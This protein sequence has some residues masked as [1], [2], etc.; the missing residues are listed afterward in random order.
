MLFFQLRCCVCICVQSH[1]Y[2]QCMLYSSCCHGRPETM[3]LLRRC[4]RLASILF[5]T[6]STNSFGRHAPILL[7]GYSLTLMESVEAG[8][9]RAV[10]EFQLHQIC[11][12]VVCNLFILKL[13]RSNPSVGH[14]TAPFLLT[15][16]PADLLRCDCLSFGWRV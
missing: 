13:S 9:Y 12:I 4:D 10:P 14:Y 1:E 8:C 3:S 6:R 16:T 5:R 15:F 2:P 11:L 7:W